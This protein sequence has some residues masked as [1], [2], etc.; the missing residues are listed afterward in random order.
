MKLNLGAGS[1]VLE[2]YEARDGANG[3]VLYPLP[4]ADGSLDEIRAS[5]VLEHWS[6][7]AVATVLKHWV[8]KLAPGGLLRIAVPNFEKIARDYLDGKEFQIQDYVFGCHVDQRDMHGCGFDSEL[9]TELLMDAGLERLHHWKSEIQD[10]AALP[11]SLNIGGYK[12]SGTAKVCEG[13][14]A[15]LSAPRFGPV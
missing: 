11:V 5:H 12:P 1:T 3:D 4:D 15:V 6:H 8:S 2:G 14:V 7:T 9:L 13:T 10:C